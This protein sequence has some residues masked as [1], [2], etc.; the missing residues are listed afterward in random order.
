M[1][2]TSESA[3]K[4]WYVYVLRCG[5][6]SLYCGITSD[7]GRRLEQHQT[8]AGARYTRGR[9]PI[10]M[11]VSWEYPTRSAALKEE[12]VFKR[13]SRVKKEA[14]LVERAVPMG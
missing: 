5:D 9:G 11:V 3:D 12:W 8:G 13:L 2:T 4:P 6:G 14:L 10:E 7:L 1:S